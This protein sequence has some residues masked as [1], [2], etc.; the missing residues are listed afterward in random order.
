MWF[1]RLLMIV[2]LGAVAGCATGPTKGGKAPEVVRPAA[3]AAAA[4]IA[5]QLSDVQLAADKALIY[6]YRPKRYVGSANIYR[7][8]V[9]G[10]PVADMKAGTRLPYAVPP[11]RVTLQ[12]RSLPSVLNI[13]L[14]L[15]L[16]EK[17]NIAFDIAA[18]KVYFI[19]VKTGF[20]GGPQFEFVDAHAGL[21]AV[22]GLRMAQSP[23][24]SKDTK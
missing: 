17:P 23:A 4:D 10:K 3:P 18:G 13:G 1:R 15:G 6:L 11:G 16:M 21:E 12:G 7:I 24:L 8:T 9:N 5:A 22:K 20:A 2:F 14:A 19:D